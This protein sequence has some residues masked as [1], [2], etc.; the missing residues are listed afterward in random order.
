[1]IAAEQYAS[2][3]V[4]ASSQQHPPIRCGS[5]KDQAHKALAKLTGPHLPASLKQLEKAVA[6]AKAEHDQ[7]TLPG[8]VAAVAESEVD[9]VDAGELADEDLDQ[10]DELADGADW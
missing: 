4:V 7:A 10:E 1:M 2:R 6:T 3:L 8:A 5:H 9:V